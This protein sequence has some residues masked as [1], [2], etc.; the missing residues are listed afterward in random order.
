VDE[1]FHDGSGNRPQNILSRARTSG[2]AWPEDQQLSEFAFKTGT[3]L[4]LIDLEYRLSIVL[5]IRYNHYS[6]AILLQ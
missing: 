2:R 3:S 6:C 4:I 5:T 1:C